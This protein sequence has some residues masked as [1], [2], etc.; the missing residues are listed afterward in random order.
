[1]NCKSKFIIFEF[2]ALLSG[3][4]RT[5]HKT[6]CDFDKIQLSCPRGTSITIEIAQYK[7]PSPGKK[8]YFLVFYKMILKITND[9]LTNEFNK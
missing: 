9:S 4:L 8:V 3:T 5:Y 7:K 2:T 1:M 6:A